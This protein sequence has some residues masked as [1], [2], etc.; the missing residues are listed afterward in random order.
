METYYFT[1][2]LKSQDYVT[3]GICGVIRPLG[4]S[5]HKVL[6]YPFKRASFMVSSIN[7]VGFAFGVVLIIQLVMKS[8]SVFHCLP[9]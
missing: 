6:W 2:L 7:S 9:K 1:S 4:K 8:F 3:V 5:L